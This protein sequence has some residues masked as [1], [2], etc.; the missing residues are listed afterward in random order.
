MSFL[1][2]Q[3]EVGIIIG[4]FQIHVLHEE[5][6]NL[7]STVL[8][9]HDRVIL[10]LGLSPLRNTLNNPLDYEARK[11]MIQDEFPTVEVHY[12][13][14]VAPDEVWSKKLDTLISKL[15]YPSQTC[16]LYGSKDSFIPYYMG[17]Y[18]TRTL[19]AKSFISASNV[20][21]KITS[22]VKASEDF[23]AGVIWATGNRF[24]TSFQT[25]DV[26]CVNLENDTVLLGRKE[27]ETLFRFIGG[28][29]D[30]GDISLENAA[31]RELRE[32]AGLELVLNSNKPL[33]LGSYRIND[34][35]YSKEIDKIMTAF[36]AV[37]YSSGIPK[38]G[39]DIYELRWASIT[40]FKINALVPEHRNLLYILQRS[41]FELNSEGDLVWI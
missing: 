7:I 34:W 5:H 24:P 41:Y 32:E 19:D 17:A 33:Y 26:A 40:D 14:D 25:V 6:K 21:R 18:P 29:V 22:K 39:S 20:R 3:E 31:L 38:A 1:K 12:I 9:N 27:D 37:S 36:F 13:E 28:F 10:F 2:S 8:S 23:R 30:P 4:R 15:L 35:R 11:L 16:I